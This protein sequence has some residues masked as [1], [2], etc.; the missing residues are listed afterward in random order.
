[1]SAVLVAEGLE[2][3]F[4][5]FVLGPLN[6]AIDQGEYLIV[7]GPSGSG[8]SLLLETLI[9]WHKPEFGT[10]RLDGVAVH[11]IPAG[12]RGFAYVPQDIGLL[13]HLDVRENLLF[14]LSCRGET[15]DPRLFERLVEV[16]G[17]AP[18]I[19]R[20]DPR[21]LSQGE[22]QRIALGRAMLTS[23]RKLFLD[24][25]CAALDPHL[26]REFQ[27]L[28]CELHRELGQTVVHVTHDRE[29][30]FLLGERIA[31]L[32]EGKMRQLDTPEAVYAQ[33]ADVRVARF[34]APEN[35]WPARVRGE[36]AASAEACLKAHD[37]RLCI[38]ASAPLPPGEHCLV[39][40]R[41]EE[42]MILHADRPLRPQV[43]QNIIEGAITR[44]LRLDG[45]MQI[46]VERP[47]GFRT[48][49]R[50][51]ICAVQDMGLAPGQT[52]RVSLKT[53]SL[54]WLLPHS[55]THRA[56]ART[57]AQQ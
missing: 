1:M 14:A 17:L 36:N 21:T 40:I 23:P 16:L 12:Q 47:D 24:E 41:P 10:V 19:D 38:S 8:K 37:L 28:L 35:L 54:Y 22:R 11:D 3:R 15:A 30:A 32:L 5:S 26:R 27:L 34:L 57:R 4:G 31:V 2:L 13:P 9:G 20:G 46:E 50:L 52:V 49:S 39:G 48:I 44:I 18:L 33:P 25:P 7:V 55:P 43:R 29:E 51:P 45:R 6:V 42:V 53:R 56:I